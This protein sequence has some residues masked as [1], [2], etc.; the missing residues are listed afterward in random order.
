MYQHSV[1]CYRIHKITTRSRRRLPR[2]RQRPQPLLAARAGP[3]VAP[4][5]AGALRPPTSRSSPWP[6]RAGPQG[7]CGPHCGWSPARMRAGDRQ[8]S[9]PS[10]RVC[11]GLWCVC[12]RLTSS[13]SR[14][15]P[16]TLSARQAAQAK[17]QSCRPCGG[18]CA[19]SSS[20][21][22][23]GFQRQSVPAASA[24]RARGA[25]VRQ[26][27][28]LPP[29][30]HHRLALSIGVRIGVRIGAPT[31]ARVGVRIGVR[32]CRGRRAA[33]GLRAAVARHAPGGPALGN[34][35]GAQT[36]RRGPPACSLR[37]E[38]RGKR[39]VQG[40]RRANAGRLP[41]ACGRRRAVR[42]H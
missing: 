40:P 2:L 5:C 28:V 37:P 9:D 21:Q 1:Q 42:E 10:S 14:Q 19:S 33:A 38:P 22:K 29:I 35:T 12:T 39:A 30:A 16:G 25:H 32:I 13:A 36:G 6:P 31:G 11:V 4:L 8:S 27:A 7:S 3:R 23:R 17:M 24:R 18:T 34:S 41:A 26:V 15:A 20:L